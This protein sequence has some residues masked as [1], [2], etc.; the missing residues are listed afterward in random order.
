M[1][2]VK[3]VARVIR[4]CRPWR[5]GHSGFLLKQFYHR[6]RNR[7]RGYSDEDHL[8]AAIQWLE[9]AQDIT[10]D[11]GVSGRYSLHGG[12]SSSY[13][14]TTGYILP[15]FLALWKHF[16]EERFKGRARK[17]LEFL[18]PLQLPNGAFPGGEVAHNKTEPSPFNTAQIL[19]GLVAWHRFTDDAHVL[20]AA[21][22]AG[23]WLLSVQD[24]DG[25]FRRHFY[26]DVTATY[27]TH[28]SCWLA[29]L[30]DHTGDVRYLDGARRHLDWALNNHDAKTGWFDGSGFTAED[31][32]AR[33]S[34]TH[35]IAYTL[36]GVLFASE[37]LEREDGIA[38]VQ[39][40]A[41]GIAK[42]L[43]LS[44]RLP[45]VL[46]HR[47]RS[48]AD[49]ACLT[50]NAQM[51]LIWM[52]FH[53]R[54]TNIRFLNAAL[55]A[56]D[57]VKTAQDM[58]STNPAI[59]GGIAGSDPIW[60]DYIQCAI[61]NWSTKYFIDALLEKKHVLARLEDGGLRGG[62]AMPIDLP[63][64]LPDANTYEAQSKLRVVMLTS[65]Q[66][67]KP[68]QMV[69]TWQSWCFCPDA[70]IVEE[71]RPVGV[72]LRL[73]DCLRESGLRPVLR[74]LL[75][76]IS[77]SGKQT[78]CSLEPKNSRVPN[79]AGLARKLDVPI[80]SV[81]LLNEPE[82]LNALRKL[83]PDIVVHA[84]AGIIRAPFLSVPRLGTINAHMGLLPRYRGMNVAEWAALQR[85][86][87]GCTVHLMDAGI[88]TGDIL[89]VRR[90]DVSTARNISELR[91][92]VDEA[93]LK[94][95][96]EVLRYILLTGKLPET[97]VQEAEEGVQFFQMHDD[98]KDHLENVIRA[99]LLFPG[100]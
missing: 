17:C 97:R 77:A 90:V 65:S 9:T 81:P 16:D 62:W 4:Q 6:N 67:T 1:S 64:K 95:L 21:K 51:A 15:T 63:T 32:R 7:E 91:D 75:R 57:L 80:F 92:L 86:P 52:H 26:L 27:S 40:A 36:W 13:P 74:M 47:W 46:D 59:R 85:D 5:S 96:G 45:G 58:E 28:L 84:G 31:H 88:D 55:K 72:W 23:D 10:A 25:A 87:V 89:C 93:Q 53:A 50:G 78:N 76:R 60:G 38:A 48:R 3:N 8:L 39:K 71:Q 18:L 73:R 79:P 20:E 98:L 68:A 19:H 33:R 100:E 14:E 12:W 24:E 56:I 30:G 61:P 66:S 42:R 44:R 29:E 37:I 49:F 54:E 22:R 83:Q 34:V 11:G 82:F 43:E 94:L 2:R 70:I 69:R 35:T 99:G 41:E